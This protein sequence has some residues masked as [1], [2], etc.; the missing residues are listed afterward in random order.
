VSVPVFTLYD[1]FEE[2]DQLVYTFEGDEAL[3]AWSLDGEQS[4]ASVRPATPEDAADPAELQAMFDR[5][6]APGRPGPAGPA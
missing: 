2:V 4:Y 3:A 5:A 6:S 1:V